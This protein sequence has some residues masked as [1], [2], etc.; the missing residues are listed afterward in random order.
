MTVK[1]TPLFYSE[2]HHILCSLNVKF[3]KNR[4][5]K[6]LKAKLASQN[7]I[8]ICSFP[9]EVSSKMHYILNNASLCARALFE[10]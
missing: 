6:M 9:Y 7:R 1:H 4:I 5:P 3:W 10:F 2:L 8:V